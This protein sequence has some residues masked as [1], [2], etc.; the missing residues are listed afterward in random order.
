MRCDGSGAYEGYKDASAAALTS[1]FALNKWTHFT[2][3]YSDESQSLAFIHDLTEQTS[4]N[5]ISL[6]IWGGNSLLKWP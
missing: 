3:S 2:I 1:E 5:S 4:L 6:S